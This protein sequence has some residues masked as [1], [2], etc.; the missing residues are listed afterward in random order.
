MCECKLRRFIIHFIKRF[1]FR[2]QVNDYAAVRGRS[3][4]ASMYFTLSADLAPV[5]NWNVKQLYTFLVAK[6]EAP[7]RVS[8]F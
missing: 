3:D 1:Q 8:V 4:M 2:K 7:E 5:F 6:Y